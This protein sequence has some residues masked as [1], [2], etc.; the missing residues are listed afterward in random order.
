MLF[1][2][3]ELEDRQ[4]LHFLMQISAILAVGHIVA[5]VTSYYHIYSVQEDKL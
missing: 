5:E 4:L 1:S 3:K 2:L